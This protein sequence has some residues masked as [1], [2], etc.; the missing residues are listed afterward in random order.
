VDI[1]RF[2]FAFG[3]EFDD[4]PVTRET[5]TGNLP[6]NQKQYYVSESKKVRDLMKKLQEA[7]DENGDYR[8]AFTWATLWRDGFGTNR[9]KN[10]RKSS[11]AWT[12]SISPGKSAVNSVSNT[13]PMALGLKK[14]NAWPKVEH[15]V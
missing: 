11:M 5:E 3:L 6:G 8:I 9:T 12:F 13:F 7:Q 1:I 14:N 15:K 10:N 4:I 2:A